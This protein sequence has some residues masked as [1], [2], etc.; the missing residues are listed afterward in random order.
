MEDLFCKIVK[1]EIPAHVVY[2]TEDTLA[3]LDVHPSAP[4]HTMV[5]LK[6]HGNNIQEYSQ[7]ELGKAMESV[8]VVSKK[9]ESALKPDS[10]TIG[11]NHKESQGVPHLHIHLIP[12]WENDKG[13]ALQGVVQ[14]QLK[15]PIE[16]IAAKIKQI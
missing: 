5:I 11:I 3:F 2:E 9:I 14:H 7:G 16:S 12:R 6:K 4:G 13:H 8:K 15:E 10:I 1:G